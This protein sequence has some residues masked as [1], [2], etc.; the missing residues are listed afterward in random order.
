M[1]RQKTSFLSRLAKSGQLVRAIVSEMTGRDDPNAINGSYGQRVRAKFG[2]Y[3]GV[4]TFDVS[5]TSYA[6]ARAI[7]Y[8][9]TY[10]DK[11]T[12]ITYGADYLLG[13]PFG[14]PIVNISAGFAIGSPVRILESDTKT[15]E[16]IKSGTTNKNN[17][18]PNAA[19]ITVKPVN[20]TIA[21]VNQWLEE[22]RNL[23]FLLSRN[24]FRDGDSFVVMDDDGTTTE[25]PPED[26]DIIT[27]PNNPQLIDGYDIWSSFPDPNKQG[28]E[29]ITYVDEIRRTYRRRMQ[30]DKTGNRVEV[31]GT[32][33]DYR[34]AIDGG[35]EERQLPVV[36][37]ANEKEGRM[38]YGISEFQNLYFLMANY[39]AVLAAAIKG[40][41]YN[42]TAVPVIQGVKNMN[43]FLTQNFTQ[44]A[45][46]KYILNW[47]SQ[48]M[49]VV[50]DGGSV[51]ILQAD[52]T[53]A[54]AQTLLN[55]LFWLISQ[56]SETPEFAFGTAVASSKA[57][58]S[59]Q[60]PMLI[61][62]A[63]RKQ[64]QLEE[65]IRR[66][67]DLYIERMSRLDS[68]NYVADTQYTIDMPDILDED[69]NINIQIVNALL[70]KGIITEETAMT[71]LNIGK[72][73]KNLDEEL[74]KA[75]AQADARNPIPTDVFGQPINDATTETTKVGDADLAAKQREL[76]QMK[77]NRT[78]S[79]VAEMLSKNINA[80]T[81]SQIQEMNPFFDG[82]SE[83]TSLEDNA[84]VLPVTSGNPYRTPGGKFAKK[85][86]TEF[87][88]N[89]D[90]LGRFGEGKD[91]S[92]SDMVR[93]GKGNKPD[94]GD[95]VANE[96]VY[97]HGSKEV[98]KIEKEGFNLDSVGKGSGGNGFLGVGVYLGFSKGRASEYGKVSKFAL[99][100]DLS[101][102]VPKT[103][104]EFTSMLMGADTQYGSPAEITK[105]MMKLGY[106]GIIASGEQGEIVVFDPKNI[107]T[108]ADLKKNSVQETIVAEFN[109]NHDAAGRFTTGK[110][111][112]WDGTDFVNND[113]LAFDGARAGLQ[114]WYAY[115]NKADSVSLTSKEEEAV[116]IYTGVGHASINTYLRRGVSSAYSDQVD[117]LDS[118]IDKG[119]LFKDTVLY[120][121]AE[122]DDP[123]TI[124]KIIDKGGFRDKGYS[125]TSALPEIAADFSKN[126]QG[127]VMFAIHKS[128]GDTALLVDK[129][130]DN[131][132]VSEA[133]ILL[134]RDSFFTVIYESTY[135]HKGRK[136]K[137]IG[138]E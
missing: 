104:N 107:L 27:N 55:I 136:I 67:I 35:L 25:I 12:G 92:S 57:S 28:A 96:L 3:K 138:L 79:K 110:G 100:E 50:G 39:H 72:Y 71:M 78:T 49:L 6:L 77:A 120:R 108:A 109:E 134:P 113:D 80:L 81:L 105:K 18:D 29:N 132:R 127:S 89:H 103:I 125:S 68:E 17:T 94:G 121:G 85:V 119:T 111:G 129:A 15:D 82:G 64:G 84:I 62:K 90:E 36:H 56:S 7:F 9:N 20:P 91:P 1:A 102:Y 30:V 115:K 70:E 32:L 38:L 21:N 59:E 53:A 128:K 74:K 4:S 54:D 95:Y 24:S 47:D 45:D 101:F 41:I 118:A 46:G 99:K 42:S 13:A 31:V 2:M 135:E 130:F 34:N 69:L 19:E 40:N 22:N 76:D 10:A 86:V 58:V 126:G 124:T 16:E 114:Q 123:A 33:N 137:L 133:E 63:I 112:S 52:G 60:T 117:S 61:K 11:K 88:K 14:K 122:F 26:I 23:L 8:A 43:Q 75:H 106:D 87:N 51:Q 93:K 83:D 131:P 66:L 44:D 48:K 97:Y 37:F 73:V 65:P 5:R 116:D 98:D